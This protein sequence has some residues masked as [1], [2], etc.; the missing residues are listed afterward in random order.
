MTELPAPT[1][2]VTVVEVSNSEPSALLARGGV[3]GPAFLR[4]LPTQRWFGSK[5]RNPRAALVRDAIDLTPAGDLW[6]AFVEVSFDQGEAET[7]VLPLAVER[8]TTTPERAVVG[9]RAK[10]GVGPTWLVD[11]S[12]DPRVAETMHRLAVREMRKRAGSVK[13]VGVRSR[14]ESPEPSGPAS[15]FT[16]DQS[17]SSFRIGREFMDK[18]VRKVEPGVSLE[19]ELLEHLARAPARAH[20]PELVGRVDATL[21]RGQT[22]TIWVSERYVENVGDAF[23]TTVAA[24]A[25]YYERALGPAGPT[26]P[27]SPA[28]FLPHT[29]LDAPP[30]VQ[31]LFGEHLPRV[32]L[33]AKRTAELHRTL[34]H[35][36]ANPSFR[37]QAPDDAFRR[38]LDVSLR[39]LFE[40][41]SEKLERAELPPL[42]AELRSRL[43]PRRHDLLRHAE[44]ALTA[45]SDAPL[46]RVH[47]DYHLGQVL[48]TGND[49]VIV[50]FAGEPA[51]PREERARRRSPLCDVAGMLRSFHYAAFG[52]L[53]GAVGPSSLD[54][55]PAPVLVPWAALH[56]RWS[57]A[58]FLSAYLDAM[59]GS[60]L[61]PTQSL[62]L[63]LELHLVEK[64]L[65]EL[66]YELDFRPRWVSVPLRGLLELLGD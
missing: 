63:E 58:V 31:E 11:A 33:L 62:A 27:A 35:D 45:R 55:L 37:P 25:R 22:A 2:R 5:S 64:A 17:N 53:T 56:A 50:D 28:P 3:L 32:E 41:A 4:Y 43:L 61:L 59:S 29:A 1:R 66:A 14:A 18:L 40:R 26:L 52:V 60:G 12:G 16:N 34:A 54:G 65:Y 13:L 51:R 42:E 7:Y 23:S 48:D 30:R 24:V 44:R 9:A 21:G 57:G 38:S 36:R 8:T 39:I 49:F 10:S 20:V 47:G 46:I 6:L 15:A 19:V